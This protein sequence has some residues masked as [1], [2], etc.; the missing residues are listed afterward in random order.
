MLTIFLVLSTLIACGEQTSATDAAAGSDTSVRGDAGD[1]SGDGGDSRVHGPRDAGRDSRVRMPVANCDTDAD[2]DDGDPATEDMCFTLADPGVCVYTECFSDEECDDGDSRTVEACVADDDLSRFCE[3]TYL[4]SRCGA[5][6]DCPTNYPCESASCNAQGFCDYTWTDDC[7][8]VETRLP[9]CDPDVR[10]GDICCDGPTCQYHCIPPGEAADCPSQVLCG[11]SAPSHYFGVLPAGPGCPSALC[12]PTPPAHGS[13]CGEAEGQ[14]CDY[15]PSP[16]ERE[17]LEGP[18]PYFDDGSPTC[19][20]EGGQWSC[21]GS[22]CPYRPPAHLSPASPP[23]W[24]RNRSER[25]E[26]RGKECTPLLH[27]G[28]LLWFCQV[29]LGAC[30]RDAPSNGDTCVPGY[31]GNNCNY[32]RDRP[33]EAV[34]T[35]TGSCSCTESGSWVCT[36]SRSSDCPPSLPSD[37]DSCVAST[38]SGRCEYFAPEGSITCRC[39]RTEQWSCTEP[40]ADF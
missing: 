20:C 6:T 8:A 40:R 3:S 16:T 36:E 27:E 17:S 11:G 19:R 7:G 24:S 2:C 29:D 13:A 15:D 18:S 30:R 26:Y 38:G 5:S 32:R 23:A 33:E 37:L 35:Y 12:P 22:W 1:D 28:E 25:C 34:D 31:E 14:G 21:T 9:T 4:P 39:A 10:V